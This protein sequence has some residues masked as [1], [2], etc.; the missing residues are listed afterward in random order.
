MTRTIDFQKLSFRA[1]SKKFTSVSNGLVR[2]DKRRIPK[3][4]LRFSK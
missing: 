1:L 3:L 2:L 4:S